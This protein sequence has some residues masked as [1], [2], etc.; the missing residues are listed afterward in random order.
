[1]AVPPPGHIPHHRGGENLSAPTKPT[2]ASRVDDGPPKSPSSVVTSPPLSQHAALW[3]AQ[4][5]A[6][7][8]LV[9]R[10]SLHATSPI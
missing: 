4:A 10:V 8:G 1:M 3:V 5:M 2:E 7:E 6:A 9:P